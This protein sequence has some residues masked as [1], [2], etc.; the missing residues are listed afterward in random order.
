MISQIERLAFLVLL[1]G[2]TALLVAVLSGSSSN[3]VAIWCVTYWWQ[4]FA[5]CAV[6]YYLLRGTLLIVKKRG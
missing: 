3:P 2:I 6:I 4:L 5:A 1:P